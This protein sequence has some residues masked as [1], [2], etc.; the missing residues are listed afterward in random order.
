M[1]DDKFDMLNVT[2][3]ALDESMD[4]DP[5]ADVETW[6]LKLPGKAACYLLEGGDDTDTGPV[7]LA[8]VGGLRGA[9]VRRM[10]EPDEPDEPTKRID[11][12]AIV[13]RVRWRMVCSRLEGDWT[14]LENARRLFPRTYRRMIRHWRAHWVGVDLDAPHPRFV[15]KD[16]PHGPAATCFGPLPTAKIARKLVESLEDIFDLCRY[17]DVLVKSPHG[18]AC[19]YK[20]MGRC[21]APC[22]G[23]VSMDVY[24]D[25]VRAAAAFVTR[26]VDG[27]ID[28]A[29]RRMHAAAKDLAFEQ[30][31]RI[32]RQIDRAGG[33]ASLIRGGVPTLA[34]M[35]YVSIQPGDRKGRV[36]AF[37]IVPGRVAYLGQIDRKQRDDAIARLVDASAK[38]TD[39]PIDVDTDD[40]AAVERIG[41]VGWHL[42]DDRREQGVY[43]PAADVDAESLADAIAAVATSKSQVASSPTESGA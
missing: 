5:A 15:A 25:Q 20:Q 12:R 2:D 22:D 29:T 34:H 11:Y 41:L 10:T 21:P 9:V 23:T 35:R 7:L 43:L 33:A 14:Y 32:K 4:I 28:D 19:S 37:A 3:P 18:E 26:R 8:T 39:E 36:R 27:W 38:L 13:R 17:H 31:G 40:L 16:V 30:A 6:R 1:A 24:R 42:A